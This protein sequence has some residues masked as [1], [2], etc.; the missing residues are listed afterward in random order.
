MKA[1]VFSLGV[2]LFIMNVGHPPFRKAS[3]ADPW[4][5]NIANGKAHLFWKLHE[6]SKPNINFD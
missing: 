1:D 3:S 4:F 5:K 2:I 6:G